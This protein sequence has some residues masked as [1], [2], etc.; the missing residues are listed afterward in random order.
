MY[1]NKW[2]KKKKHEQNRQ[3]IFVYTYF[4]WIPVNQIT[5]FLPLSVVIIMGSINGTQVHISCVKIKLSE[6]IVMPFYLLHLI[7][8]CVRIIYVQYALTL[9]TQYN[10]DVHVLHHHQMIYSSYQGSTFF[11]LGQIHSRMGA[12]SPY[13]KRKNNNNK[14]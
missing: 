5:F 14:I 4:I 10:F 1:S 11:L 13:Q 7:S 6:R 8:V 9:Q 3:I 2:Q 12:L